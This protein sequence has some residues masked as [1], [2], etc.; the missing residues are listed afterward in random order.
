[1]FKKILIANRGEI[2]LRIIRG[3]KELGIPH[4]LVFSE[5]DRDS[6]PVQL[7]D[8]AYCIGPPSVSDSYLN[9]HN[10]I[11]AAKVA[12]ADAIHPGYGLLSESLKFAQICA[13]EEIVFIGPS[14]ESLRMMGDKAI[15]RETAMSA[16]V[17]VVPGSKPLKTVHEALSFAATASYPFMLKA[18]SGGGGKGMRVIHSQEELERMFET[19]SAEAQSSFGDPTMYLEKYIAN[20]RHIEF[21][22]ASDRYG[23]TLYLGERDCTLQRRNQKLVEEAPAISLTPELRAEMGEYAVKVARECGYFTVGT[24]EFI[25]DLDEDNFYFMEMNTRIQVEHPVT[26]ELTGVDLV[27]EQICTARGE[28]LSFSEPPL[29]NG[30]TIECRINAEDPL[31]NFTPSAGKIERLVLPGGIGVRVDTHVY[32]GY[33]IPPYYDS[34]LAKIIVHAATRDEALTRMDRALSETIIEGVPT[35]IPLHKLFMN[36]SE[37]RTNQISTSFVEKNLNRILSMIEV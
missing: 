14:P 34:M 26:E 29:L 30:H 9:I 28:K 31:K 37:F 19:A 33:K 24:V 21:Q 12:H 11:S 27:K 20:A 13:A 18:V 25:Y 8:E 7:A 4:A 17:P 15:A 3:C 35:T 6:L 23:N 10:L 32:Q 36:L 2:A 1:M 16:G 22:I 5:A